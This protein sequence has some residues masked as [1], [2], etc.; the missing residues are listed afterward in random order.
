MKKFSKISE[1]LFKAYEPP[2]AKFPTT[3]EEI[4]SLCKK[5]K[6]EKYTINENLSLEVEGDVS[7]RNHNLTHLP[8]KFS[9][10]SGDFDCSDNRLV[11]LEGSPTEVGGNFY[12]SSN[13]LLTLKWCP[14]EISWNFYCSYNRLSNLIGCTREI[15]GGF[16]CSSNRLTT[17]DGCPIEVRG[18]FRWHNNQIS[19]ILELFIT[20]KNVL[21]EWDEFKPVTKRVFS[22]SDSLKPINNGVEYIVNENKL[23]QLYIE[24]MGRDFQGEFKFEN[25]KIDKS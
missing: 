13:E 16:N 24:V 11:S 21:P 10:T 4:D 17:L 18:D 22:D 23:R 14:I 5:Y 9:T 8:L 12:C 20:P 15:G 6:I 7:F 3:K 1:N 19:E 25:Y 2:A